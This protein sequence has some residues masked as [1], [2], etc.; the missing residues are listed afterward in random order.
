M[1]F[2]LK[3]IK[4]CYTLTNTNYTMTNRRPYDY[5][6][7]NVCMECNCCDRH[8]IDRP[9]KLEKWEETDIKYL[10]KEEEDAKLSQ[11]AC[12]CRHNLRSMCR[13]CFGFEEPQGK[14]RKF[15]CISQK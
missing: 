6:D 9:T 2:K 4:Q 12:V 14:K 8:Q 1:N 11:C 10:S 3:L 13:E 15:Q 5:S 7:W